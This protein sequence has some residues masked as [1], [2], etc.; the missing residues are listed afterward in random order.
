MKSLHFIS[1]ILSMVLGMISCRK[2]KVIPTP[3]GDGECYSFGELPPLN[4]F[5][6]ERFQ[7]QTPYF[8]PNNDN[9]FVF[10][11]KDFELDEYKLMKYNIQTG[12]KTVLVENVKIISQP[13]WSRK[14]WIAFDNVFNQNYQIWV[15][16]DNG[17]SLIQF[18]TNVANLFP[19]WDAVGDCL[20]WQHSPVLGI[21][22][23]FLK[24]D[25]FGTNLDTVLNS[26]DPSM[27]WVTYN[28][29]T[30]DNLLIS[31]TIIG[32][33]NHIGFTNL[34]S[35]NFVSLVSLDNL[36]LVGLEG[37]CWSNNSQTAYFTIYKN[38]LYKLNVNN[39]T[40]TKL[41]SFCDSKRYKSISCSSDGKK[42][43][44]ERIDSYLV[45]DGDGNP[46]G[47]IMEKSHIYIIDLETLKE[48][49]IN[50]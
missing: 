34:N 45:K 37:L 39:G 40:Y 48:T 33:Q 18:T 26:N 38:G 21:P 25:L 46:T 11:Y 27:G 47:Q 41:I 9:E 36:N 23:Y 50:L 49:K 24:R 42:L 15:V 32:N 8:N 4:Y 43:I 30:I 20:F 17:D 10:N 14:G 44:G 29:V 5:S 2:D 3:S 12:V 13:K 31:K 1:L 22:S 6:N 35:P 28:D 7:Y 16:K 19:V